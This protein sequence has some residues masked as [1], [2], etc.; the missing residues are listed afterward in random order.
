VVRKD[1]IV[2]PDRK[3]PRPSVNKPKPYEALRDRACRRCGRRE[4]TMSGTVA[5]VSIDIDSTPDRVWTALTDPEQIRR[6]MMGARVET[7]W[8]VGSRITWTG[9]YNGR[10]YEDK[11]E[12]L[13]YVPGRRLAM[14]HFSPMSGA[15]DEPANYHRVVYELDDLLNRTHVTLTQDG[16]A[17]EEEAEHSAKNWAMMFE[18]LK[19]VAEKG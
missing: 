1:V 19:R 6:F 14:T 3:S 15:A 5:T 2:M 10:T 7:D 8:H 12:I 18:G 16:N 13:E 17:S 4:T 11:G 9:E